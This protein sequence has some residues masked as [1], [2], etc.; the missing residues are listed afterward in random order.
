LILLAALA[1]GL[2]VG[3]VVARS[4]KRPWTLPQLRSLW[5]V[6][7]AF[8]PQGLAFYLPATRAHIPDAIAAAGLLISQTLL[9]VF[10]WLNRKVS[11]IWLLA[12]GTGLNLIVI[13]ANGGFMPISPQTAARLISADELAELQI[14]SRFGIKDILLVP[15][16][17]HLAWL[18]DRFV[19]PGWLSRPV[20]F[21]LGDTGI[22]AGAFWLTAAQGK[23]LKSNQGS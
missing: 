8:L 2:L 17:T 5:L 20:A 15:G 16:E 14:G 7:V 3:A 22:A 13:A 1:A 18:S 23:P 9:L 4:Q 21:S 11:G 12:L 19:S 6:V 10:C